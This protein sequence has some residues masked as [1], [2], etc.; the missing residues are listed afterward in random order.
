MYD[1]AIKNGIVANVEEYCEF[2]SDFRGSCSSCCNKK[3]NRT[4]GSKTSSR[5]D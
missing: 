1:D 4:A 5:G 2:D 3:E